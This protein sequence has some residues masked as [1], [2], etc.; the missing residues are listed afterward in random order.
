M[1][2]TAPAE[3]TKAAD[4]WRQHKDAKHGTFKLLSDNGDRSLA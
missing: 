2:I 1:D 3:D 4:S